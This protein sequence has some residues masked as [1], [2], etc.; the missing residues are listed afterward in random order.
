MIFSGLGFN[1]QIGQQPDTRDTIALATTAA[2]LMLRDSTRH[3]SLD[4]SDLDTFAMSSSS[5]R[6][7][8]TTVCCIAMVIWVPL[9]IA[10]C[11]DNSCDWHLRGIST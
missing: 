5:P 1:S 6:E 9:A 10:E 3:W 8:I 4:N 11:C 2:P 7:G